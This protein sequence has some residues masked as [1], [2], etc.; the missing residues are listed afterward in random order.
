MYI[1]IFEISSKYRGIGRDKKFL[2]ILKSQ[3][4]NEYF[5]LLDDDARIKLTNQNYRVLQTLIKSIAPEDRK[6]YEII[7]FGNQDDFELSD[8]CCGTIFFG[9]DITGDSYN[10]SPIFRA[11]FD[12]SSNIY[13]S[14]NDYLND[15]G[16][17]N[18]IIDCN[19]IIKTVYNDTKEY[20]ENDGLLRPISIFRLI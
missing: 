4:A 14:L 2:P 11:V 6:K 15:F 16:L 18:S 5:S 12:G 13:L 19:N 10:E 8:I 9:Y 17:C 1:D 7:A 20:F 3:L